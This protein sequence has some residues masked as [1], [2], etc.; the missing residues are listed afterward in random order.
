MEL[1]PCSFLGYCRARIFEIRPQSKVACLGSR[2]QSTQSASESLCRRRAMLDGMVASTAPASLGG[3]LR[4][5][6][7]EVPSRASQ[8][9][10]VYDELHRPRPLD[11][12]LPVAGR[13][14]SGAH[15]EHRGEWRCVKTCVF[16][17][18]DLLGLPVVE[19][20]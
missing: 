3:N 19:P 20:W 15:G 2:S 18:L 7:F 11:I 6:P 17:D 5:W 16:C 1:L 4:A 12:I 13:C 14:F 9:T 10:H 8:Q